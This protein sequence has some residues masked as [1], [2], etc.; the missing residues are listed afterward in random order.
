MRY[1]ST[2][3]RR[4][5]VQSLFTLALLATSPSCSSAGD[6]PSNAQGGSSAL[7]GGSAQAGSAQAGGGVS[8]SVP[9]VSVVISGTAP[10]AVSPLFFGQNYWSWVKAWGN[11]VAAT[12]SAV[13]DM[14]LGLLRA[15]GAN[16]ETAT[17]EPFSLAEID[18][19]VSF[20][21]AI[22]ASPLLQVSVIKD[23]D[24]L[25][26]SAASAAAVVRYVNQTKSYGIKYFSIGNEPDLYSEQGL[27]PV[28]FDAKA[29]CDTVAEYASAM[30]AADPAIQISGPDLS[31]KYQGGND[32]LTPFLNDCGDALDI[33]A[34]HRYPLAPTATTA[35]AAFA[36]GAAFRQTIRNLRAIMKATG[37]EQKPLAITE[38]NITYDGDPAKST[39]PASPGTFLAG[40][41]LADNLGV[42]LE[43]QLY[44]VSYW[45]LSEGWTLG[46]FDGDQPRPAA[47]IL[48][49]FATRFG[50]EVLTVTGAS[51][52]V[53]VY[54][55]R[56]ASQ[57]QSTVFVVNKSANQ[58]SI[59]LSFAGLPR[60]D[61][62]E[63][64]VPATS[65]TV[66]TLSDDGA[67]PVLTHYD[68]SMAAPE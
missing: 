57:G 43:E 61:T 65:F 11:S 3:S 42:A 40:L 27:K 41:W 15:G 2:Y 63:L 39:L 52:Q 64:V 54:A 37:Q 48:K 21:R 9:S 12:K 49:L 62:P 38:A 20:S 22:G 33:V 55:G 60:S 47:H 1:H 5:S 68:A 45:S 29:A 18:D 66:A 24:G 14:H 10:K 19:F 4:V 53:S 23:P 25:P 51:P 26:A 50:S 8:G 58:S 46:F 30:R 28:G 31:W 17:P 59:S 16:N 36:D 44:N 35:N 56:D 13:T 34:V 7:G 67:A 6:E 32:W